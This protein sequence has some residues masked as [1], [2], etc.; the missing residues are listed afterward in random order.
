MKGWPLGVSVGM[1]MQRG[2]VEVPDLVKFL[3]GYKDIYIE[4]GART[5]VNVL[6]FE[7]EW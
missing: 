2:T 1:R 7:I 6:R 4:V 5:R 3:R